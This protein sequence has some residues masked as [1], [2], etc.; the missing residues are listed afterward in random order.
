MIGET[1]AILRRFCIISLN[2]TTSDENPNNF[3][4]SKRKMW[5]T[6]LSVTDFANEPQEL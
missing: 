1:N 6:L 4:K 3:L 5:E 2:F